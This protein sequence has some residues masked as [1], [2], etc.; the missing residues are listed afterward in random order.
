MNKDSI[1]LL[2]VDG[3]GTKTIAVLVNAEGTI[4]GE[5]RAGAS[6]YHVVGVERAEDAIV[7]AILDAFKDAGIGFCD[8]V[9]VEKAVF[10]LAGIDTTIDEKEV[11]GIVQRGINALSIGIGSV[12]VEND[13]LSALFGATQKKAGVLLIAGTGS[14]VFAHDGNGRIVRS[15]GW[16]HR[17]GD[18]GSGYW[19]GKQAIQSVLKM[20]DGREEDTLLAKLILE[21]FELS[22]IEDL[23]NWAYSESYSV[24]DVGALTAVVYEAFCLGDAVSKRIFDAAVDELLVLAGNAIEKANIQ[25]DEF[26]LILQGGVFHNNPYIKNQFIQ[27]IQHSNTKVKVVTTSEEPIR[28]IIKRGLEKE[29]TI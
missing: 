18:E 3:G 12:I 21:K 13:A 6:N 15:G 16:G 1:E 4:I 5:G 10:A 14:I 24:D 20:K 19:I 29:S 11:K 22:T 26:D 9:N 23:Y 8:Q 7:A 17:F 27:K 2:A 28:N 25:Q